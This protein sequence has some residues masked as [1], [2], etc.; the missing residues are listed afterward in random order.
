MEGKP[1]RTEAALRGLRRRSLCVVLMSTFVQ[2]V[3]FQIHVNRRPVLCASL[4]RQSPLWAP[5]AACG[6]QAFWCSAVFP[7][8]MQQRPPRSRPQSPRRPPARLTCP[9]PPAPAVPAN[10]RRATWLDI[11]AGLCGSR[12]PGDCVWK[13]EE[14]SSLESNEEP[15]EAAFLPRG[16]GRGLNKAWLH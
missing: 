2:T 14:L 16:D 13:Q 11:I 7:T 3:A 6:G 12:W 15:L 5:A 4:H 9:F 1:R 8:T 10:K